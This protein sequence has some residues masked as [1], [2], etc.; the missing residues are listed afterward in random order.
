MP[1]ATAYAQPAGIGKRNA[2][3]GRRPKKR[4]RRR[5]RKQQGRRIT[6]RRWCDRCN[7]IHEHGERC[8][9]APKR[10]K[11]QDTRRNREP[12][13]RAYNQAEYQRNRQAVI[14]RTKGCCAACGKRIAERRL[15]KWVMKGGDVHHIRPLCDG[16]GNQQANLVPL[17]RDCHAKADAARRRGGTRF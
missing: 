10:P 6:V 15:G 3:S 16:G 13:R 5:R 7:K 9:Q 8:P 1:R 4:R 14:T 11:R 12:H 2:G 17:C